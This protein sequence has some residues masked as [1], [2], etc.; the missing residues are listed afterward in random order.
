MNPIDVLR[1]TM[2]SAGDSRLSKWHGLL[3][4]YGKEAK[5]IDG[6][7][8]TAINQRDNLQVQVNELEPDVR[9][10]TRRQDLEQ[11]V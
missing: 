11:E 2:R 6:A 10:H 9:N 3:S 1:E 4:E 7:L 8:N 5:T